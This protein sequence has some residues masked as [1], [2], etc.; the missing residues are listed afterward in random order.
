M[1]SAILVEDNELIRETLIP[2]M[3]ELA[4]VRVIAF[5]TTQDE[6]VRLLA[7]HQDE[8]RVAVVDLFLEQG[9]GLGV[10]RASQGRRADQKV[11]VLSNYATAQM[12]RSCLELGA[13]A[14]FDKSTELDEF[15]RYCSALDQ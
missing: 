9:S 15:F 13:D 8:W 10:V 2:A 3:E 14:I 5:A 4:G 1:L 11:V 7:Q 12:R 6:G